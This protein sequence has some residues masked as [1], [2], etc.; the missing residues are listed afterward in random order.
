MKLT[1]IA[2]IITVV[3]VLGGCRNHERSI[4]GAYGNAVVT[5]QV[6]M[7]ADVA[8]GS[9]AGVEIT[10]GGTG[11]RAVLGADGRFTFAGVPENAT[12]HLRRAADGIDTTTSAVAGFNAIELSRTTVTSGRHRS[13]SPAIEIEGTLSSVATDSIVVTTESKGSFTAALTSSTII[14]KGQTTV[15]P[16]DLKVGDQVHVKATFK[17]NTYTAVEVIVQ[18]GDNPGSGN[19]TQT[20]VEIEGTLTSAAADSIVV[21]TQ[22]HGNFTVA[23]TSTTII[24]KGQT[25][26]APADLKVGDRVHVKATLKDSTYT[27]TEVIVQNEGG[28]SGSGDGAQ[29]VTA[30][31]IVKSTGASDM[32]VHRENGQDVTV[33]VDAQTVISKYGQTIAFSDI[34]TGDQV[35][36]LGTAVDAQTILARQIEVQDGPGQHGGH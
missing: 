20:N 4:T 21:A 2:I 6:T 30:N 12:L 28:D 11:M 13:V 3:L 27:A 34:K 24:R 17:D 8:N 18:T 14:R 35:E 31:G 25:T 32:V 15:A 7:A 29:A 23:L 33:Q 26:V 1:R 19:G 16:A 10:V 9:P 22:S 5:G 36:C